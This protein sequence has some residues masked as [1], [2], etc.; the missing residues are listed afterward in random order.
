MSERSSY[1]HI[2]LF[3]Q[4]GS[5]TTQTDHANPELVPLSSFDGGSNDGS[6]SRCSSHCESS[7]FSPSKNLSN[8]TGAL[9][10]SDVEQI[11]IDY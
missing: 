6:E 10:G 5:P 2:V 7:R 4:I 8:G 1:A 3:H 9:F 11:N